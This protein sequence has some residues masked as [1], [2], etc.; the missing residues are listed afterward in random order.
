[1]EG[2]DETSGRYILV[3][4]V[5]ALAMFLD[6][7]DGTIVNVALPSIAGSFGIGTSASSWISTVYFLVMAG[8]IL[9]FGK[10]CDK[11]AVRKV[12]V[13][14]LLLFSAS[15]LACGLSASLSE[16]IVFRAVQGVGASMIASSCMLATVE[17]LPPRKIT[18]GLSVSLLGWSLGA[19]AGPALGGVLTE[20]LSWHWIFLIN[21]PIGVVAAIVCMKAFPRDRGFDRTGFDIRGS[22][23]LFV[24]I[25]TGLFALETVPSHGL[26]VTNGAAVVVCLIFLVLFTRHSLGSGNAVLDLRL[27]RIR[28]LTYVVVV[29][30]LVNV[31]YMGAQYL[32]PF[33]LTVEMGYSAVESS[34]HML[35][36]AVTILALC[37]FTGKMAETRG[38]RVFCIV[39][40]VVLTIFSIT[41]CLIC[42]DT[43][44]LVM[45]SLAL[46]GLTWGI[47][48]GPIGSRV[49]DFVPKGKEGEG[50][51]LMTFVIY[52]GSAMGTALFSGLFSLGSS[53]SGTSIS[54]LEPSVFMD[55]FLFSMV[56]C[57]VMCV[58]LTFLSWYVPEKGV[59]GE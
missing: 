38:N 9:I 58:I 8:L 4:I 40:G 35:I 51:S 50:S 52:L 24:C 54:E 49:I 29:L 1:M 37:L 55:G 7:L 18:F 22:A 39:G 31:C 2:P 21:V 11:G 12:M 5:I 34:M 57:V 47:C 13:V 14:G 20:T 32:F 53:S 33:F 19:A 36:P 42:S 16:L 3:Y 41:A 26:S 28:Q 43:P 48:G 10:V 15:S 17:F 25:V 30:L 27:F 6:G 59:S 56:T 45:V 46:L 44:Y 23:M